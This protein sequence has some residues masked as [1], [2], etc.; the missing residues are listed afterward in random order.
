MGRRASAIALLTLASVL[1]D[2]RSA[3]AEWQIK[4]FVGLKFGGDTTLFD[5]DDAAGDTHVAFGLSGLLL[6]EVFGVEADVAR[7]PGF[8]K[9]GELVLDGSVTTLTGNVVVALPRRIAEYGLR[10]YFVLGSGLVAASVEDNLQALPVAVKLAVFDVGGGA[11]GFLTS[12]AGVSWD[13]RWFRSVGGKSGTGNSIGP[14][15]ISFWR[16]SMALA[17]R[18]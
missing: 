9:G 8:F 12:R 7:V 18:Y 11:T 14:E 17:I 4:P 16:A 2:P 15:Q 5:L 13:I 1:L 6:G 10:P 3:A